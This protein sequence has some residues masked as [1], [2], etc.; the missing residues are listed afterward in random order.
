MVPEKFR[1]SSVIIPLCVLV[2]L[3]FYLVVGLSMGPLLLE[4]GLTNENFLPVVF[5]IGGIFLCG[6]LIRD[7]LKEAPPA[8]EKEKQGKHFS[9]KQIILIADFF[10][11]VLL[12]STIGII[13]ASFVFVFLFMLFFDDEIRHI[14]K[15]LIYS[16][17]ITAFIYVLYGVIFNVRF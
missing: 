8:E 4:S 12:Y 14:V 16:A 9:R 17:L 15:K 3:V 13:P 10:L 2:F 5:S 7:G 6:S 1:R 11:F